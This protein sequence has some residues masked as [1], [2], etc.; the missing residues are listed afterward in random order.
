MI[1]QTINNRYTVTAR[2][3]KGAMGTVY[4]ATDTQNGR[5]VAL[6]IIS[7]ELVVEPEML[8]R[9]KREGE[10][11]SKLKHPNIVG[12]IDAFQHD[13]HYVI[14]MEY[15]SGGSLY[16]LIKAGALPIERARQIALDLCDALIRAHRLNIIHRDLKPENILIDEDDTPKLADFGVA[17]LSEGTRMTRSGTQVGTPY[18]MS[19]EAWEG[20]ALDAQADIWSLGVILFEMLAGQVPFGGDTGAAVMNKVLTTPL[21]DLKKLRSEVPTSLVKI[22]SRMLTRDKSRR[23]QTIRQVAVD[24]ESVQQASTATPAKVSRTAFLPSPSVFSRYRFLLIGVVL[25]AAAFSAIKLL[26]PVTSPPPTPAPEPTLPLATSTAPLIPVFTKPPVDASPTISNP[27]VPSEPVKIRWFVGLGTGNDPAQLPVQQAVVSDFNASHPNIQLVLEIVPNET[28]ANKLAEQIASGTAPDIVGPVGWAGSNAFYG[29]WLDITPQIEESGFDTSIFNPALLAFYRTEEGQVGL[30]FAVFPGGIYFMPSL[31][32]RAGLAYPPQTYGEKYVLDGKEV[33]WNW[34][35]LTEV[36]RRLTLDRKGLNAT[37]QGFD[38]TRIVQFGYYP[39]WQHPNSVASFYS[40]AAKIYEGDIKGNYKSTIPDG[41]KQAWQWYY[42]GMY[43]DQPFIPTGPLTGSPEFGTG[44]VFNS[45][46]VAMAL[47][48]SWYTCC[49]A[50]FANAGNKFQLGVQPMA[51]DGIV[52]GRID[53]D[54]F[55]ILKSTSHP[56]QAFTVLS[57]LITTG[58]D[59]LL[60]VYGAMPAIASKTDVF[61]QSKREVYPFVTDKSWNVFVQGLAYPDTP[62]AE[63]YQPNWKEAFDRQQAFMNLMNNTKNIN[64]N[65]TFVQLVND[66]NSIYNK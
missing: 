1:G 37:Q 66:L 43:G 2:I 38:R 42:D 22:V 15:V 31:F 23:Y 62:S 27:V 54:T 25:I 60:P 12:F 35:T 13:E 40:G 29:Q 39:Q 3:G 33:D 16:E 41:W 44:N 65:S 36:A 57:Y 53:A 24:L 18:Y 48:Q 21:P 64:L 11:L 34:D 10:A 14:V 17:K 26:A 45:G 4:R 19:P 52:H 9:F 63:Q 50:E 58:G 55:R 49:L 7:S 6:K 20:R 59:K 5:E 56:D 32:D 51:A 28:A 46:K 8:E 61:F 47:T 30:P